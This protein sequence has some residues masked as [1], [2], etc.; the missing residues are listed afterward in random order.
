MLKFTEK[1]VQW[2]DKILSHN[3]TIQYSS[4]MRGTFQ[5]Q[6]SC[7]SF[8]SL[9][10]LLSNGSTLS[11]NK[12]TQHKESLALIMYSNTIHTKSNNRHSY[13]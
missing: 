13:Q 6:M 3:H 4:Y 2:Q 8:T 10:L 11:Y 1:N 5:V 9:L 12:Y 7:S